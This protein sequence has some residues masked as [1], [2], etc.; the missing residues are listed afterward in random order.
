MARLPAKETYDQIAP[1][2]DRRW[3]RYT[4]LTLSATLDGW[5]PAEEQRVLDLATGT[6]ELATRL[7]GSYPRV[8]LVG[9]D[10]SHAML[11]AGRAKQYPGR[12][13]VIQGTA[14]RLPFPD[15][16]F[17]QVV[18]SNSFH[19]FHAPATALRE[20]RR[21]L[22]PGGVFLLT[23][24]C[25]DYLSCKICSIYLRLTDP[26]FHRA[27]TLGDCN[28]GLVD[29]GFEV[30]RESRFKI[31]WLWGLMRIEARRPA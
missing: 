1:V 20:V 15:A 5:A 6:G 9:F 19:H 11:A 16:T 2:Y 23:D 25:N 21:V 31:D 18:R 30:R 3:A 24:W 17:H 27:Y 14:D 7:L 12:Y 4:E 13:R 29:A 8:E 10:I 28:R 22:R 26:S